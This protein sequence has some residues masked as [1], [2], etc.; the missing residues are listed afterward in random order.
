MTMERELG[1]GSNSIKTPLTK[2]AYLLV[3]L[4]VAILTLLPV[5][6]VSPNPVQCVLMG[7]NRK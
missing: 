1:V 4:S 5:L 2:C 6:T 3:A 7:G